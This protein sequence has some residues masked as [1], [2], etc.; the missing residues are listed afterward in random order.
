[1]LDIEGFLRFCMHRCLRYWAVDSALL[2]KKEFFLI[3]Y[4]TKD[5]YPTI[6]RRFE[7]MFQENRN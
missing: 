1:M 7:T 3:E 4:P 6:L 2:K 5:P